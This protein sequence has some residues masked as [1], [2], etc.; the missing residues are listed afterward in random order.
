MRIFQVVH[1][2]PPLNVVAGTGI[3]T[4]SLSK[5]L[6]KRH[7]IFIFHRISELR[8]K[9]YE[10]LQNNYYDFEVYT[11]NNTF[12]QYSSFEMTYKNEAI[13]NRFPEIID[14]IN[15]D[16]VHIQH[17]L[18]L[19]ASIIEEIRRKCIPIVFTLHDYWLFCPQGQLLENNF[20]ICDNKDYSKCIKCVLHQL[21]IK[22]NIFKYY[23]FLERLVPGGLL[24][25]IKKR[26]L[27][28]AQVA[29]LSF[30][31]AVKMLNERAEYMKN[32][33]S[34]VDLFIAPSEF[35]RNKFIDFGMPENKIIFSRYGFNLD[36]FK[37]LRKISSNKLRFGFI[38]N[39]LPAKGVHLLISAFNRIKNDTIELKIYGQAHSYKSKLG[40]YLKYIKKL[41]KN[42]NIKFMGGF[43]NKNI[44]KVFAGI[45]VLV[46]PSIW[47]ENSPLVIQEAF[48]AKT[49]VIASNIGGISELINNGKNGLLF[50]PNNIDDLLKK[51]NLIIED[52]SLLEAIKHN[53]RSPK[54][55]EQNAK[56]IESI[57]EDLIASV[58]C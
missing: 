43:D 16:I 28:Y 42:K 26:Y 46:V 36:N 18:Y 10:I 55:I 52:P 38:G 1:S 25:F 50:E 30:D 58:K 40:N 45:D 6:A 3:Y 9:D 33:C 5:E 51:I 56:E 21:T 22:E 20:K 41:T 24:Q 27:N 37:D 23:Y 39:L 34:I 44:S 48:A 54:S 13:S 2:F 11:I 31:K 49:P 4:Y 7:R 29:F 8:Q 35:L 14:Q 32:I 12:K 15:P 17:L 57:Y 19:S 53:L 47:Y